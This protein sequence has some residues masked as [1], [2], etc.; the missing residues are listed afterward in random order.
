MSPFNPKNTRTDWRV[1]HV[2]TCDELCWSAATEKLI[3]NSH[4]AFKSSLEE[5]LFHQIKKAVILQDLPRM[6]EQ[7]ASLWS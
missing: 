5:Y 1:L 7:E 6:L 4:I 2:Q 3:E